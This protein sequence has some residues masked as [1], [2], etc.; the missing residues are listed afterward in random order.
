VLVDLLGHK[1][2]EDSGFDL[3]FE[4]E[5]SAGFSLVF[6]F[7]VSHVSE[8]NSFASLLVV[9]ET[10]VELHDSVG[11]AVE[12]L[13]EHFGGVGNTLFV[14]DVVFVQNFDYFD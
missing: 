2:V 11:G 14:P 12:H 4:F 5:N 10:A 6:D 1:F 13:S 7:S 9:G 8:L 3:R